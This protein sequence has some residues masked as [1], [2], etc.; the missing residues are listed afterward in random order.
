MTDARDGSNPARPENSN[1]T[2]VGVA[3]MGPAAA[4]STSAVHLELNVYQICTATEICWLH[5][6]LL[7]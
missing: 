7:S 3:N 5:L 6:W 4:D 1:V 2:T